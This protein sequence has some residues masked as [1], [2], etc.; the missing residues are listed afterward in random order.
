MCIRDSISIGGGDPNSTIE[1]I[2]T[3]SVNSDNAAE[4]QVQSLAIYDTVKS[5]YVTVNGQS[6]S[7]ITTTSDYGYILTHTNDENFRAA[8]DVYNLPVGVSNTVTAWFFGTFNKHFNEVREEIFTITS[9][10][11]VTFVLSYPPNN[12]EPAVA[13]TMVEFRPT[14]LTGRRLLLPPHIDY[15]EVINPADTTFLINNEGSFSLSEIRTYV[16]GIEI[17]RGF[18]FSVSDPWVNIHA[19]ILSMGDVVAIV[20]TPY[21]SD[22]DY[23]FNVYNDILTLPVPLQVPS[24]ISVI[25]YTDHDNMLMRAETFKGTPVRRY[26]I[27]R[28]VLDESYVWVSVNGIPLASRID[29]EVLDD[30]ITI[31]VSDAF[32]HTSSDFII[33]TSVSGANLATNILG[34]RIFNDIFNRTHFKRLSKKNTT[35]LTRELKFTDTEIYVDDSSA[36]TPPL[37]AKKIPGVVIIDGERIEFFRINGNTL[38]QLRRSTLGTAPSFYSEINTKVIDQS[39]DQT[40]PFSEII[41][42]QVIRTLANTTIYSI[43]TVTQ[44][45]DIGADYPINSDG[46]IFQQN[47]L[48]LQDINV[49]QYVASAKDQIS[50]YYG[51]RLLNKIGT[52]WHDISVAYDSPIADLSNVGFTS[53]E[54]TLPLTDIEGTAYVVLAT[55]KVWVYTNSISIDSID[56]YEYKGLNYLPPEFDVNL[57]NQEIRLNIQEGTQ[58]GINLIIMKKE[59]QRERVWNTEINDRETRSLMESTTVPAKFLQARPAELPEKYYYGGDPALLT[60]SGFALIDTNNNPLQEGL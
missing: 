42:K 3:A 38:S 21:G 23:E 56:G 43:S 27:S 53:T 37:L 7:A 32:E 6:I 18:D 9:T 50:V 25:T 12:I 48:P 19:G 22:L 26:K 15:Y 45:I 58:E 57:D 10:T 20:S 11:D 17:R 36:L 31:Q 28:P 30:Q 33:I 54:Y 59:F 44:L 14:L 60:D 41:R 35:Y 51:G 40:V 46:I 47:L 16:S 39:P 8:I 2:D 55:N 5:A 1:L 49:N 4:S 52:F 29:Y 34:Y 24:E 13:N